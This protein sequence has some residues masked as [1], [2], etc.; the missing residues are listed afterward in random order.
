MTHS[1]ENMELVALA[2]WRAN[3]KV[4]EMFCRRNRLSVLWQN[5]HC[6]F[7]FFVASGSASSVATS[8][9]QKECI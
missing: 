2:C 3:T 8:L 1:E 9:W 6:L 5:F 4:C 7:V